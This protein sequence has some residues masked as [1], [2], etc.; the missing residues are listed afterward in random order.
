[1]LSLTL[2]IWGSGVEHFHAKNYDTSADFYERS[3]LYLSREEESRPG[4]AQCLRVL[5][6]CHLALK[7]LDR[8]LEFVNE[9]DK[10]LIFFL[11]T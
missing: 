3:M 1:L 10:V 9:A 2:G 6:L 5:T 11:I 8:A 4:R 7:Q